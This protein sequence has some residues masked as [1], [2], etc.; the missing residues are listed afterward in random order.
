MTPPIQNF[1][2]LGSTIPR[3]LL[4]VGSLDNKSQAGWPCASPHPVGQGSQ[5]FSISSN[6]TDLRSVDVATN[7]EVGTRREHL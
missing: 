1:C 5:E 6:D 3:E 4:E 7:K 2:A